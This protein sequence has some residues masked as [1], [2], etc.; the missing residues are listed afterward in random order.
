LVAEGKSAF[1]VGQSNKFNSLQLIGESGISYLEEFKR[2]VKE[3]GFGT[4]RH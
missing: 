1:L 2:I 3:F 4:Y